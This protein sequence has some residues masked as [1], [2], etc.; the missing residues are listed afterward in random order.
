MIKPLSKMALLS[1]AVAILLLL[2]SAVIAA[3]AQTFKLDQ[4]WQF[5]PDQSGTLKLNDLDNNKSW[6]DVRVGFSWNAQFADLRDYMGVG[7]Y[8]TRFE[9]PQLSDPRRVL[10]RFGA[11]DYYSELFVNGKPVG[12]HEGGY[13][14]FVFDITDNVK[15]GANEMVVRVIDPPM[16]EEGKPPRF[17]DMPYNE[18]PHGKQNWYVQTGGIWQPV[19]LEIKPN[20]YI[21]QVHVTP[22]IDGEV[23]VEVKLTGGARVAGMFNR[24]LGVKVRNPQGGTEFT[25]TM[26][27]RDIGPHPF[28]GRVKMPQL[29][30]PSN[31]SLYSVEVTLE[32][33]DTMDDR[34]GF[35]SFEA[36][37]HHFYLNGE[38]FYMIAALDQDFYPETIYTPPSE[39]YVRDMMLK[40]KRLGL[41]TLRCHIKVPDPVYLKVADEMGL[42]VW[43]EIPSW[44]DFHHFAPK[45]AE[46]GERIFAEEVARDWNH[47][48]IVIQSI[49]N[50]S[51]GAD[52]KQEDQRRWLRAAFDRGKRLTAPLGRLIVD[53]SACCD[54][55]HVRTDI[56]DNHRYNSI[57]DDH[58]AFDSWVADFA[59]R[60]KWDFSP[61]GDA[62][63]TGGE[64]LV[65]SEFGN[66]GLPRL[67][68]E[69]PWW[70]GRDF[71]G[72]AVTRPAGVFDRFKEFQFGRLFPDFNSLAEATEWHEFIS[73]KHEIEEIRRHASIQGYV[74]TELT[75]INWE[76][77]GL[78]D[79]WRHP[80]V[81]ASELAK[82][83]QPDVILARPPKFNY[84]SGERIEIP[85]LISH[86]SGRELSGGRVEWS[87]DSGA[88]G[89][90]TL[91]RPIR[92]ASVE[93]LSSIS[94]VAPEV[95]R[96][97]RERLLIEVRGRNDSLIA[98]NS[99][100]IF[101]FSKHVAA[102]DLKLTVY[103][104]AN[105][106]EKLW[107]ALMTSG[108]TVFRANGSSIASIGTDT[109]LISTKLDDDAQQYLQ[110]GG[111]AIVLA[112]SKEAFPVRAPYKSVP[113]AGSDLD[114]NWVTNF[115]WI[116]ADAPPFRDVAFTKLLGFESDSAVPHYI[117]QGAR[118]AD[119]DDVL[120][121]IFYGWLNNNA[122]LAIQMRAGNGKLFATTFRFGEYGSDPYATHLLDAIIRYASGPGFSPE[123]RM[124]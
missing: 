80:K 13:T 106:L 89:R 71:A 44:N 58:V 7:W 30:S 123:L 83:Q 81:Y 49:I 109:L 40:A 107:E 110:R 57:P 50:E 19:T 97:R 36:R 6:R 90:F 79:M 12:T 17:P 14:P 39:E 87:T 8:R 70:F 112:D 33:P 26:R 72:R 56:E 104:P 115:N 29:W 101:L 74:I 38:T 98:E 96:P 69:L 121:G 52:L 25:Q 46:R 37:D 113:R 114:G 75:D 124:K 48:S 3:P 92:R 118:G 95:V 54:N 41:N 43:Y 88:R 16:D 2:L 34:F 27:A 85:M 60:P 82:I 24:M 86:Y 42:L 94:F 59:A 65:L 64:P 102:K 5:L 32:G 35:R 84:T 63:R 4:G 9:V 105:S 15:P 47:P 21:E 61:Y 18:I 122:A 73:L 10:L 111:R 76:V 103:D 22:H 62:E 99:Y 31:P 93:P 108:Y 120:A 117:I 119:Y 66:W 11:V 1:R 67:P 116:R 100:E 91:T 28:T 53:N 45:A 23:R 77:N 68:K 51:W 20:I 55:F 78:M